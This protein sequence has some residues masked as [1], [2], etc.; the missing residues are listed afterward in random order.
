MSSSGRRAAWS[1]D[2]GLRG[3]V[4]GSAPLSCLARSALASGARSGSP[5]PAGS[6]SG[7]LV[8]A[9]AVAPFSSPA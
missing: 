2:R 1:G 3:A 5:A 4:D 8:G 6:A 7:V 9:V